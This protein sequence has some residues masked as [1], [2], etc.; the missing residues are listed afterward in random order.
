MGDYRVLKCA[1]CGLHFVDVPYKETSIKDMDYYWAEDIYKN[2]EESIGGW[3]EKELDKIERYEKGGKLLDLGCS[4]GY[5]IERASA[6]GWEVAGIEISRKV[7]E[8]YLKDRAGT[9]NVFN[10]TL[11]EAGYA[12]GEFDVVTMFDV[13][14][15][16]ENPAGTIDEVGR[17]LRPGGLLVVETPREESLFKL[18]A[19]CLFKV[20]GRRAGFL[21]RSAYNPHPGGHRFGFTHRSVEHLLDGKGFRIEKIEKRMMPVQMFLR[22]SMGGNRN[23]VV[24]TLYTSAGLVLWLASAALGMQNRMVVYSRKRE[25]NR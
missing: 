15:H 4:F 9:L 20:F 25:S 6:R 5:L 8:K 10:G 3:V 24:K 7:V 1:G 16:L 12:D 2:E 22:A 21:I 23:V 18:V 14:E 13:I 17:V 11:E 19:H